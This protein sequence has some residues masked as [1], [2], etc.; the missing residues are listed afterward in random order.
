MRL[1]TRHNGRNSQENLLVVA[2]LVA[3]SLPAM[4]QDTPGHVTPDAHAWPLLNAQQ[5]HHRAKIR[6]RLS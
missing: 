3:L 5:S 4:T 6:R 1:V 2:G